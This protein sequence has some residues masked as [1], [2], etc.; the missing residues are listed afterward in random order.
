MPTVNTEFRQERRLLVRDEVAALLQ[1]DDANL[2]ELINTRQLTEIRICGK[3]RF[4]SRDVVRLID[5]YKKTQSR[6]SNQ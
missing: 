5:S 1:L 4:D 6:R 3:Q 2:Q